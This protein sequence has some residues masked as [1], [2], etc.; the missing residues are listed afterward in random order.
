M[1]YSDRWK[2]LRDGGAGEVCALLR[3]VG[4]DD[5]GDLQLRFMWDMGGVLC[6]QG[7]G[8]WGLGGL[9]LEGLWIAGIQGSGCRPQEGL[10][11]AP[12]LSAGS[13]ETRCS[14]PQE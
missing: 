11:F 2:N 6:V 7:L 8:F 13:L 1:C 9:G 4:G 10:A 12:A 14:A 5:A 3:C